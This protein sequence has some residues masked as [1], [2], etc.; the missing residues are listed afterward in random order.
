MPRH[1]SP[2]TTTYKTSNQLQDFGHY[3]DR[4]SKSPSPSPTRKTSMTFANINPSTKM[5]PVYEEQDGNQR[6]RSSV[7]FSPSRSP[8]RQP[9]PRLSTSAE[10]KIVEMQIPIR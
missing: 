7:T 9:P 6:H 3:I 1:F 5:A 10:R 4:S 8:A 2:S